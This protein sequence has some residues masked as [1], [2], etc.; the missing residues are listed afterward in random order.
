M[1]ID[2]ELLAGPHGTLPVRIYRPENGA[3][4]GL[5]WAH[6][7]GF[8]FGD[9]DMP[10]ADDVARGL[11]ERG[12]AVVSVD[13]RLAPHV[14]YPVASEELEHA[15][16]WAAASGIAPGP[17]ALGGA[18][19]GGNLAAGAALRMLHD[20]APLPA[21]VVLAYP[22]TQTVQDAVPADLRARLD[23]A[24]EADVFGPEALR[25]MYENYLG[26][27]IEGAPL[28]ASPGHATVDDLRGYPPVLMINSEVDELRVGGEAF[29]RTLA[30]ASVDVEV[31][32]EPG[33]QHGHLNAAGT[34]AQT[35][36]IER[37]AARLRAQ[38]LR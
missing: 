29:A 18:S 15:F 27:P 28:S 22:T 24:P 17:W 34:P 37:I 31:E 10:E 30:D 14:R 12:I 1:R 16:A 20:G 33:T 4:P 23:A 2:D 3:G 36:T 7:G 35:A 26:G 8:A 13:Y 11:A 5:V 19:A 9:L 38:G 25:E 21:L 32:I 6:G